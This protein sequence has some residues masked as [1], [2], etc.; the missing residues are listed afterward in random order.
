M[1]ALQN[2]EIDVL[3]L[4]ETDPD[5]AVGWSYELAEARQ[6]DGIAIRTAPHCRTASLMF[7]GA[8]GSIFADRALRLAI[9]HAIDREAIASIALRGVVDN[10]RPLNNFVYVSGEPEYQDNAPPDDYNPA[11]ARRELDDL[12]W[13]LK[14]DV[15]EKDGKKLVLRYVAGDIDESVRD[16]LAQIGVKATADNNAQDD[17]LGT[18]NFDVVSVVEWGDVFMPLTRLNNLYSSKGRDNYGKNA[19]EAIDRAIADVMN[20]IDSKAAK[21]KA[22]DVDKLLWSQRPAIPLFQIPNV[23]AVRSNVVNFVGP[24]FADIDFTAIALTQ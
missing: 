3:Q 15:R 17:V 20:Q 24:G 13:T 23:Y 8:P 4:Q 21:D 22:N 14:G 18:G 7:N 1:K 11:E 12:G 16:N 6:V 5:A 19:D 9:S 2:G 10:P